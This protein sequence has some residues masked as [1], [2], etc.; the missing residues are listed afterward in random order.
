M[1]HDNEWLIDRPWLI[2]S[3]EPAVEVLHLVS[4]AKEYELIEVAHHPVRTRRSSIGFDIGYWASGNFSIICDSLVW[5]LWHPPPPEA[6]QSLSCYAKKLNEH[7]LFRTA[8]EARDFCNFYSE[9]EWAESGGKF[10]IIE[11]AL[12]HK[13]T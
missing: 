12:V 8:D 2:P 11:I 3:L 4:V 10:E 13:S 6:F 1:C 7:V 9:Q 5:P